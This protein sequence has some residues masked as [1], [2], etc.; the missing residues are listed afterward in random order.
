MGGM[1]N[2]WK[3]RLPRVFCYRANGLD[4]EGREVGKKSA[5][6]LSGFLA[7]VGDL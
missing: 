4:L 5:G 2:G 7:D 1:V 3:G 6:V